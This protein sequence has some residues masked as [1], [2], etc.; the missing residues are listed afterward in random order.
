[1]TS[2]SQV[3]ETPPST[4]TPILDRVIPLP[5]LTKRTW[6]VELLRALLGAAVT[7]FL[8]FVVY[9]VTHRTFKYGP[10]THLTFKH[11]L[12]VWTLILFV[13]NVI[14]FG[15]SLYLAMIIHETGHMIAG[16]CS[17]YRMDYMRV[18][19]IQINSRFRVSR[20]PKFG[21]YL[22][23]MASML[24]RRKDRLHARTIVYLLGGPLANL[25][26]AGCVLLLSR[27]LPGF[28]IWFAYISLLLG[29]MNLMPFVASGAASDG[30]GILMIWRRTP[31][32]ERWLAIMQLR[33]A[34]W[35]GVLPENLD[36]EMLDKATAVSDRL[37]ATVAGHLVAYAAAIHLHRDAKAARLLETALQYYPYTWLPG[38][39]AL[40]VNAAV[41]QATRGG[42]VD[43]AEQWLKDLPEKLQT[44]GLREQAEAAILEGRKEPEA[45]LAKLGQ[46]EKA[47]AGMPHGFERDQK[48]RSVARWQNEL[49]ARSAAS[50][51]GV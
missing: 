21:V 19:P 31:Q 18:G 50:S 14:L 51:T 40:L 33:S 20:A 45:A 34:L 42:R 39:E 3:L 8:A 48:L 1:M 4:S 9:A 11:G 46:S 13:A 37:V 16:L 44:P 24:P 49:K 25:T 26:S 28:A 41:F 17:G 32:G 12:S 6:K 29:L 23:G 27:P 43:L 7:F 30:N 22:P 36:Q 35:D 5:T 38:K 10:V 15:V 2:T 47:I